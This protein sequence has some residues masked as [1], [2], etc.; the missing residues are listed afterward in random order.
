[1]VAVADPTEA[2][3]DFALLKHDGSPSRAI[4]T[5]TSRLRL[6]RKDDKIQ[7]SGEIEYGDEIVLLT[8]R[9]SAP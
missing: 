6:A 2:R 9:K 5:Y 7:L 1:M 8:M 4:T 3:A